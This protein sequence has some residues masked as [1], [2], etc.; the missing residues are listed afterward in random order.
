MCRVL[1]V[2]RSGFYRWAA[3]GPARQ[4]RAAAEDVLA[5]QI[6]IIHADS[7]GAY[8]S[9][10]VTVELHAQGVRVNRKRV[11]RIMRQRDVVVG[12]CAAANAPPSLT[13]PHRRRRT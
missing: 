11:E 12:T 5:E 4:A 8:G 10:R 7:G 6:R 1:A 9:P 2:S 3:S 13:R